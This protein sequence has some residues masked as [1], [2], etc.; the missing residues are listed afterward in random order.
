MAPPAESEGAGGPTGGFRL[1][2]KAGLGHYR[3]ED[4]VCWADKGPIE[5]GDYLGGRMQTSKVAGL[6]SPQQGSAASRVDLEKAEQLN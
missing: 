4:N 3:K 5:V 1:G 2:E 6:P